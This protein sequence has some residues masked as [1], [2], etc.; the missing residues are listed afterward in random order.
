LIIK[1]SVITACDS[2]DER[3]IR[4]QTVFMYPEGSYI[5]VFLG[6]DNSPTGGYYLTDMGQTFSYLADLHISV[7]KNPK[8]RNLAEQI[9]NLLKV[10]EENGELFIH[11]REDFSDAGD[12]VFRLSQ[13]C[14]R[15]ADFCYTEK[16]SPFS[17]QKKSI[18][19]FFVTGDP[20]GNQLLEL[21]NIIWE[22]LDKLT[23]EIA[24]LRSE[25]DYLMKNNLL[26]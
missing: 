2:V 22:R 8:N 25:K 16:F 1:S 19:E 18:K 23:F 12:A 17:Y 11:I 7:Y 26:S 10:H 15:I 9:C 14:I 4:L 6:M 3:L 20:D 24:N 13:A 5:D 21:I